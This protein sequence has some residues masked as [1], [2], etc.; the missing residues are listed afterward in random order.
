MWNL[1]VKCLQEISAHLN[2]TRR[3]DDRGSIVSVSLRKTKECN[4]MA[5]NTSLSVRVV[6]KKKSHSFKWLTVVLKASLS[7]W[8]GHWLIDIL[9]LWI[10]CRYG[11]RYI[12]NTES[13]VKLIFYFAYVCMY[14]CMYVCVCV[15]GGG[16]LGVYID[17]VYCTNGNLIIPSGMFIRGNTMP[18]FTCRNDPIRMVFKSTLVS[19][20]MAE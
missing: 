2:P 14:V 3:N 12:W 9:L 11:W 19:K 16:G 1:Q 20:R 18:M 5:D 8:V 13:S 15:C 17:L 4:Q 6:M 10:R 7:L